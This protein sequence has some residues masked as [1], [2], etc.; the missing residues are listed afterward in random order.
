M[1]TP[2]RSGAL[3]RSSRV[4]CRWR[5]DDLDPE[6]ADGGDE[7]VVI[8]ISPSSTTTCSSSRVWPWRQA[9]T[10]RLL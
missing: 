3:G 1:L 2:T 8:R 7:R 5:P 10:A 6:P 4:E 9:D